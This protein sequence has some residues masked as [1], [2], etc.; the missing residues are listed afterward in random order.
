M[1]KEFRLIL[2]TIII[3]CLIF[4]ISNIVS[5]SDTIKVQTERIREATVF[6]SI[7]SNGYIE[8]RDK[9]LISI[10]ENGIVETV[11]FKVGDSV[12]KGDIIM[13]INKTEIIP[14]ISAFSI[15][16]NLIGRSD[17]LSTNEEK[18]TI[19]SNV[20]GKIMSIPREVGKGII[21]GV[22]FLSISDT[23]DY[24][25]RINI[26][27]KYISS[28]KVGQKVTLKGDGFNGNLQGEVESISPVAKKEIDIL[29]SGSDVKVEVVVAIN[30]NNKNIIPGLSV[31][32]K[33]LVDEKDDAL[34]VPYKAIFQEEKEEYVYVLE[35]N[36]V[37]KKRIY[38]GYELESDI[39]VTAGLNKNDILIL[40]TDLKEGDIIKNE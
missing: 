15:D 34:V 11:N 2:G 24:V 5:A 14:T 10:D 9:N 16:S 17:I 36:T 40:N 38:T 4:T 21:K 35:E 39:E 7:V 12:A 29:G 8:Q 19:K 6:N 26:S 31:S 37:V 33:I 27:E 3:V 18:M 13:T 25:A 28:V 22:P 20:D 32:A 30:S 1:K 23:D